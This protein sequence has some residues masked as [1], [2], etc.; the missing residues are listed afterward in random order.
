MGFIETDPY[1]F[2]P[3]TGFVS[4]FN[5]SDLTG[6][7]YRPT[8]AK[9]VESAKR[10][11]GKPNAPVWPIVREAVNF[12]GQGAAT[13]GATW[14]ERGRL[15]VTTPPEGRKIQ[16]LS[17]SQRVSDRLHPASRVPRHGQC[18][19]RRLPARTTIA[20]PRL[21]ARRAV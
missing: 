9:D 12:D 20:M 7:G 13:T 15:I 11:L 4:L 5:G 18:R 2:T 21:R 3:E 8:S 19:Q 16:Q 6:W 14:P 1:E 10:D 17:T